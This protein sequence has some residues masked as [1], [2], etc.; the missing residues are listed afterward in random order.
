M[1]FWIWL[2]GRMD[3]DTY[4]HQNR[5][6]EAAFAASIGS[7]QSTVHRLRKGGRLPSQTVMRAIHEATGGLV[8]AAEFYDLPEN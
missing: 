4:L 2:I 8:T 3:L 7:N 1:A 5:I 6:T